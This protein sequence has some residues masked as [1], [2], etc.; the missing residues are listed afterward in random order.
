MSKSS[1][2]A[3]DRGDIRH[4]SFDLSS[5]GHFIAEQKKTSQCICRFRILKGNLKVILKVVSDGNLAGGTS[6]PDVGERIGAQSVVPPLE[7]EYRKNRLSSIKTTL[8]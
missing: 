3:F 4:E 5:Y 6:G 7:T 1:S 2:R 8:S